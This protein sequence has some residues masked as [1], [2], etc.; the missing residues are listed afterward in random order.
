M[1][2]RKG[3]EKSLTTPAVN[4]FSAEDARYVGMIVGLKKIIE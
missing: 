4:S 3:G 1:N 2:L